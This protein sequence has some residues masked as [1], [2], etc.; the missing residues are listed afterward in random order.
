MAATHRA[1]LHLAACLVVASCGSDAASD[2][3]EA[4]GSDGSPDADD[5]VDEVDDAAEAASDTT[6]GTPDNVP[7]GDGDD[8]EFS[9]CRQGLAAGPLGTKRGDLAS[10]FELELV[11]GSVLSLAATFT[12]CE[13]FVF[14]SDGIPVSA[15][16]ATSIWDSD[17]DFAA[18]LERS[19][20]DVHYI[21]VSTASEAIAPDHVAAMQARIDRTLAGL[22]PSPRS[23]WQAHLHVVA[24]RAQ[25]LAAW[26]SVEASPSLRWPGAAILGH[27]APGFAI[28]HGQL[29]RGVGSLADV[30]RYDQ[31]LADGGHWAWR[32]NL[33]YAAYEADYMRAEHALNERLA[34]EGADTIDVFRGEVLSQFAEAD[35]VFPS[36]DEL[37]G[38]DTVEIE[39]TL[40]CPD[41][42][43]PEFGNCGAWDY[44][45]SLSIIEPDM[46]DGTT[47][48]EVARFITAYHR[49]AHWVV[50]AT[51][52][53][54]HVAAGGTQRLRWEFAPEWN[55][56]PTATWLSVRFSNRHKGSRPITVV[57]L[58]TGGDFGST[59][60]ERAP[61]VVDIPTTTRRA[62]VWTLVT[63]HGA[64]PNQCA[65]FCAHRH[66]INVGATE[67]AK[68]FIEA[69]DNDGCIPAI[70]HGMTP[71]QGGTWWTGR[72]GWCPGAAV[73]P[74]VLDVSKD[75]RPG[76]PVIFT[77]RGLL[78]G[79]DPP[80]GSGNIVL[81]SD[82]VLYE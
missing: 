13:S 25:A 78:V 61:V 17:A 68:G 31:A 69:G 60:N 44:L 74:W 62:E 9:P 8:I 54:A 7:P 59:Y 33:A 45:A 3:T 10:D 1:S 63:G 19:P 48:H 36:P 79:R 50:D 49:E 21:F 22:G 38:F 39:I 40:R 82:L 81:T 18:L 51:P 55:N 37:A 67:Y 64:G 71:N 41:R 30:S 72:G 56:Q 23:H 32:Q 75:V 43:K 4:T 58:F 16:D 24:A 80:D 47:P 70:E 29:I 20:D 5:G 6:G 2:T 12:G 42:D 14:I 66:V 11:D 77:Y 26:P 34:V 35:V 73:E 28:D 52:L 46:G 57:P 65:E 15:L 76:K 27:L 53:L